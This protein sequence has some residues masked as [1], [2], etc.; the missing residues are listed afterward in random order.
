MYGTYKKDIRRLK[1]EI[2]LT[3]ANIL[4]YENKIDRL[5]QKW[6]L[7]RNDVLLHSNNILCSIDSD[8][9]YNQIL[10]LIIYCKGTNECNNRLRSRRLQARHD[11]KLLENKWR[12]NRLR[13]ITDIR[14]RSYIK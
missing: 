13:D 1:E 2:R 14:L 10:W 8:Q 6:N 9:L 7:D 5:C 4:Y 3:D 12:R 11:V